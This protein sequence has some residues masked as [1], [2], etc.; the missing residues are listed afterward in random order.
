MFAGGSARPPAF[1]HEAPSDNL[2]QG[3]QVLPMVNILFSRL[4]IRVVSTAIGGFGMFCLFSS[5]IVPR[6]GA[7]AFILLGAATALELLTDK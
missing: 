7:D 4:M 3:E 6:F 5:F 1:E 2:V